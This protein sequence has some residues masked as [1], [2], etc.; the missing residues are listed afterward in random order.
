MT[1]NE[2]VA[3]SGRLELTWT[4]K[5]RRLLSHEDGTYEWTDAGDYRV[6]E[7]RLLHNMTT[8]GTVQPEPDRA[9]DNL[10]IRGDALHALSSLCALPE[11]RSEY[12]GKV[13]VAYIDPPFNTGQA[14]EHY[15]DALEHSVWLT[16]IRDRLTEIRELLH[17]TGTLWLHLDSVEIHRARCVLDEVFGTANYLG[18]V[19]WQRTSAKSLARRTMGTL[20]ESILVYGASEDAE[21][22]QLFA[23]MQ[24]EYVARRFTNTDQRGVYDTGD[25]TASSHRPHLDSGQPWRGFDPSALK[26][27]WAV[28][29]A[30]LVEAGLSDAQLEQMTMREKLDALDAA[31]Y[32]HWSK[33]G[34][35]RLKKYLH[36]VKG[37][38][39]GDL[40]TDINVINSQA[41]ERSGFS[42]Q[43]PE[44][45]IQRV[46]QMAS[47]PGDVVLDCFLGS[48]TTAA[49]AQKMGRRWVGVEWSQPT[50]QDFILPRLNAVIAGEDSD[51][52]TK[53]ESWAGGGGFRV[54]EVAPSMFQVSEGRV[55]LADW[56]VGGVLAEAV[57]AQAG[58]SFVDE[59]PFSGRKGR[60]RLA[61]IDGLVNEAV[62]RLLLP[63][64]RDA[65]LLTVYGT[66]VD[67]DC[68]SALS[69]LRRGSVLRKMPE[70]VLDDYRRAQ[71]RRAGALEW[72][73][74]DSD[75]LSTSRTG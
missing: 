26:R 5:H 8:C 39:I 40:W 11:F 50:I 44:A 62:I 70:S 16:M 52:I 41:G 59:P 12:L 55:V 74:S 66:A 27:C 35:P 34:F 7:I 64:L 33:G 56:A 43:K 58:F 21:L 2:Q 30:P 57:A 4:N 32:V 28:P 75:A 42:T 20:H 1:A 49:C 17:P 47:D 22:N 73:P 23:P 10:L 45:L 36:N 48:G 54:V 46:L 25:L 72:P 61:V 6:A 68:R 18:T 69:E 71:Q 65:E 38:V 29:R 37:R 19:I 14:F 31:G 3:P 13:K 53:A 63:W 24:D 60:Q 15:D 51:G 9:L 67:P